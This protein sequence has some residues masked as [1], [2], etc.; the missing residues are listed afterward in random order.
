[1][2]H[3][4]VFTLLCLT[5]TNQSNR[6]RNAASMSEL[7]FLCRSTPLTMMLRKCKPYQIQ[8]LQEARKHAKL[9]YL[10][11]LPACRPYAPGLSYTSS[12]KPILGFDKNSFCAS[13]DWYKQL[14]CGSLLMS[15]MK[16]QVLKEFLQAS[17]STSLIS[18][19]S[20][21]SR[22]TTLAKIHKK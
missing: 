20:V 15:P 3:A 22:G 10:G 14:S 11:E 4:C 13:S 5:I 2:R 1:M 7:S 19:R 21:T 6:P 9:H 18:L 17:K 12:P 8:L 16:P